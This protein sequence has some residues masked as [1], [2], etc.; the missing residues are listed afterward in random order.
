[1]NFHMIVNL[2]VI[3]PVA[4]LDKGQV[5]VPFWILT[6]F[7]HIHTTAKNYNQFHHACVCLLVH[8]SISTE[9]KYAH[10]TDFIYISCLEFF[11]QFCDTF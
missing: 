1:M 2:I 3:S 5:I 11:L 4:K 6:V 9:Q 8:L 10:L 7:S